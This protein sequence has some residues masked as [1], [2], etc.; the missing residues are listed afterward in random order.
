MYIRVHTHTTKPQIQNP[1]RQ[2]KIQSNNTLRQSSSQ[3]NR[4]THNRP[5]KHDHHGDQIV[6]TCNLSNS[7]SASLGFHGV[8][9][10]AVGNI[11]CCGSLHLCGRHQDLCPALPVDLLCV[12][13][14]FLCVTHGARLLWRL[15]SQTSMEPDRISKTRLNC[16][17]NVNASYAFVI[18]FS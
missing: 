1:V 11:L 16:H 10:P 14:R 5:S 9:R 15:S 3:T 7:L 6:Q 17:S 18:T 12:V 8:D 2:R 13:C 4:G